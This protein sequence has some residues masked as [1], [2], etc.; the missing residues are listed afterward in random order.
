MA[1]PSKQKS[2]LKHQVSYSKLL[3]ASVYKLLVTESLFSVCGR[4]H[5]FQWFHIL[6]I[7]IFN[8]SVVC[9]VIIQQGLL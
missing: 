2:A 5:R 8:D 3:T 4:S 6:Y 7:I 9:V 1:I